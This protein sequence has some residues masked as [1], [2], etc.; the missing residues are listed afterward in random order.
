MSVG[1]S[2]S[3]EEVEFV[4]ERGCSEERWREG[5]RYRWSVSRAEVMWSSLSSMLEERDVE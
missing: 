3:S 2:S 5:S 4:E 1:E